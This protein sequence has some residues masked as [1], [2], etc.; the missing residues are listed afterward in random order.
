MPSTVIGIFGVGG[1]GKSTLLKQ[2][3]SNYAGLNGYQFI[4]GTDIIST[5]TPGGLP[6]FK[7]LSPAGKAEQRALAAQELKRIVQSAHTVTSLVIGHYAF[8]AAAPSESKYEAV[9]TELDFEAFTHMIYMAPD[10]A[11][12]VEQ[13]AADNSRPDRLKMSAAEIKE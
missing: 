12:V 8:E 5:I 7:A 6:A 3:Q 1:V 4:E 13:R 9:V 10:P 11:V 2:L